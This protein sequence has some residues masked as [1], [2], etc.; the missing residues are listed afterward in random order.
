MNKNNCVPAWLRLFLW[1]L[2]SELLIIYSL[3]STNTTN[4]Y[5]R[6]I[7]PLLGIIMLSL[8]VKPFAAGILAAFGTSCGLAILHYFPLYPQV[9]PKARIAFQ[10]AVGNYRETMLNYSYLWVLAA[11]VIAYFCADFY[12][13]EKSA[14]DRKTAA[15]AGQPPARA[16]FSAVELSAMAIFIAFGVIVTSVRI[17][18]FSFGGLPIILAGLTLGPV[19]GFLVGGLTDLAAFIVRP[20]GQFNPIFTLTS[21]LTGFLPIFFLQILQRKK[22][23]FDFQHINY[24]QLLLVI[25]VTQC[26]TSV[27]IASAV[28]TF[29]YGHG[30]WYYIVRQ[31]SRQCFNVPLYAY[32]SLGILQSVN[33]QTIRTKMKLRN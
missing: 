7:L 16:K 18:F 9:A 10:Q 15:S 14:L 26:L 28:M 13:R 21:A 24:W 6:L 31:G 20:G 33:L 19:Y 17:G 22:T 27:L 2:C 30:F 23:K 29:L 3:A 32:L 12:C 11:A 1:L 4:M 8:K 25:A 5:T